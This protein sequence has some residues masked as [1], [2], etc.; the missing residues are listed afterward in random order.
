MMQHGQKIETSTVVLTE[1]GNDAF[2]TIQ[3]VI[4]KLNNDPKTD[5]TK[6]NIEVF[7]ATFIGY[8]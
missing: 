1:A 6:I 2:G 8:E 7:K 4:M 3:E 5:W